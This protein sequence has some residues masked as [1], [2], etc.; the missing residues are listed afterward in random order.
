MA[1]HRLLRL[2]GGGQFTALFGG[3]PGFVDL[4]AAGNAEALSWN[5][6]GDRRTC[7]DVRAVADADRSDQ[8]RIA[9]NEDAFANIGRV[10]LESIVV[11][12]DGRRS[13]VAFWA[14]L[15]VA[16]VG[17]VRYFRTFADDRL[18]CF[19]KVSDTRASL[20]V[21]ANTQASEWTDSRAVFQPAFHDHAMRLDGYVVAKD[22][23]GQYAARSNDAARAAFG[24]AQ[25]LHSGFDDGVF[26][27]GHIRIDQDGFR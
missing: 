23:V 1:A 6:I 10:F 16:Q 17:Q 26:A 15:S 9:A 12:C 13:D 11:A 24:L 18:F 8:H 20:Q 14:H 4:A 7:G 21:S 22:G 5:V 2:L 19:D 27:C 3:P 25:Q